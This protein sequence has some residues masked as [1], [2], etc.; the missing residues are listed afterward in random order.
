M[1]LFGSGHARARKECPN[2]CRASAMG[3]ELTVDSADILDRRFAVAHFSSVA[4]TFVMPITRQF[5]LKTS[6]TRQD[7]SKFDSPSCRRT[8]L[9]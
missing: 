2:P 6:R 5:E 9:R 7:H 4:T 8:R 1:S 3:Q